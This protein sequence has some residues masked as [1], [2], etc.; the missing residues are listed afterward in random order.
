MPVRHRR[1][2]GTP[3][4]VLADWIAERAEK[5]AEEWY[6]DI[7]REPTTARYREYEDRDEL[8]RDT[9]ALY[10]YLS[11]WLR[12]GEWDPRIDPHYRRIGRDRREAGF[13]LSD[14]IS[15]ILVAKRHLWNGIIAG[16]QLSIALELEV[17]KAISLFY[18]KAIYHTILG[19]EERPDAEGDATG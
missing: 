5:W 9:T 14:V 10:H 15:A 11:L 18:D 3:Q 12:T 2:G 1:Y 6:E 17:S 8:I 7:Q 13:P 4:T 16:R 19:Y